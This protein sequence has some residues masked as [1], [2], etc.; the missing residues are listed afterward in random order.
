MEPNPAY[1]SRTRQTNFAN[2]LSAN[3]LTVDAR[4]P[5]PRIFARLMIYIFVIFHVFLADSI[6]FTAR[7]T[8]HDKRTIRILVASFPRSGNVHV[9]CNR[10]EGDHGRDDDDGEGD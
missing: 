6:I 8:P 4:T 3:R 1:D 2:P 9:L 7:A 10:N 5:G